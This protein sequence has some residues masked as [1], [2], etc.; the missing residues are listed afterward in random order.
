MYMILISVYLFQDDVGMML[1]PRLEDSFE[2]ALNPIVEDIA[3]V[4]G[5]PHQVVVTGKHS[6]AHS[7]IHGHVYS[8]C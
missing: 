1:R 6:V 4:F 8:I 5:R 2:I 3:S 7:A